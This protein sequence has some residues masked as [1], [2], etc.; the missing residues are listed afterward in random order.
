[1]LL[2]LPTFRDSLFTH[3]GLVACSEGLCPYFW[4]V[5]KHILIVVILVQQL[6]PPFLLHPLLHV[7]G[8]DA[9]RHDIPP[10]DAHLQEGA[11][12][13][14]VLHEVLLPGQVVRR[15]SLP[16][17]LPAHLRPHHLLHD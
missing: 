14:L 15:P 3:F 4:L 8:H 1:M 16:D 17:R 2:P 12:Q 5:T 6:R 10:G 13:L 11:L 7:H 9:D